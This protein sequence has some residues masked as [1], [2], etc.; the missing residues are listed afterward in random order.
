ME[1][2]MSGSLEGYKGTSAFEEVGLY[3]LR[4]RLRG[5]RCVCASAIQAMSC[6]CLQREELRVKQK[7]KQKK[8]RG[9]VCVVTQRHA[10]VEVLS[11]LHGVI[12][13]VTCRNVQNDRRKVSCWMWVQL[14]QHLSDHRLHICLHSNLQRSVDLACCL[15]YLFVLKAMR[16][17]E[18][19]LPKKSMSSLGTNKSQ[20]FWRRINQ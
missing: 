14:S 1:R 8:K 16:V 12:S 15:S 17:R 18:W 10:W 11:A 2:E 4:K 5:Q 7:K 9:E 13:T 6:K 19:K 3:M 20:H